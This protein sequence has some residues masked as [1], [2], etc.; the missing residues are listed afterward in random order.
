M[1]DVSNGVAAGSQR[2]EKFNRAHHRDVR[3]HGNRYRQ[4]EKP[5]AP[6][7]KQNGVGHQNSENRARRSDRRNIRRHGAPGHRND[8][9][10]NFDQARADTAQKKEI[11]KALFPPDEFQFPAKH[12][13]KKHV[14]QQ[15][16]Q[17]AVEK[18][19][20][21][22]LPQPEAWHRT[23]GDQPEEMINPRR[24]F[25][26]QENVDERLD[27]EHAGAD[28]HQE[29]DAGRNKAAPIEVV[30]AGAERSSHT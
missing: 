15:M 1:A 5:N 10:E 21:E 9:D 20:R 6:V 8:L 23:E 18:N 29:L 28:K 19:V 27:Q 17:A 22:R 25:Y 4:R 16:Q 24:S 26:A 2:A 14:H 11:Q 3:P 12:P 30:T 13:E 7:W